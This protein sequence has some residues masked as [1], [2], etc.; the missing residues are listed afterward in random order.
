MWKKIKITNLKKHFFVLH[1]IVSEVKRVAF[2]SD[3]MSYS[4]ESLLA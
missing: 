2:V 3:R 1:R 4:Y